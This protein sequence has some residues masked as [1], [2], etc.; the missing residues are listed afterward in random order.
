MRTTIRSALATSFMVASSAT[1]GE[2]VEVSP[3]STQT[4][5][6]SLVPG[7]ELEVVSSSD[8]WL[9]PRTDGSNAVTNATLSVRIKN[10]TGDTW[11]GAT[12]DCG[13]PPSEPAGAAMLTSVVDSPLAPGQWTVT[14]AIG[15]SRVTPRTMTCFV[16]PTAG[17]EV[18]EK[19][20]TSLRSRPVVDL[21]DAG[22]MTPL[23]ARYA[24]DNF[25]GQCRWID[26]GDTTTAEME[27]A[28]EM[29][30]GNGTTLREGELLTHGG[31]WRRRSDGAKSALAR[32][33]FHCLFGRSFAI[34]DN[35]SQAVLATY[36]KTTG[37]SIE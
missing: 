33:A 36:S 21:F 6:V 7:V 31:E 4:E 15:K 11:P 2:V 1:G 37:L 3:I 12:L 20:A 27:A 19:V 18:L 32:V 25:A 8:H 10:A 16:L 24:V 13:M 9:S 29:L 28:A 22:E 30:F 17:G 23:I 34:R 35:V 26:R 14:K 5:L